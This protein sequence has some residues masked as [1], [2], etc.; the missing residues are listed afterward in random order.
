MAKPHRMFVVT[1]TGL[2]CAAVPMSLQ[3]AW[4][5]H[6]WGFPA[7]ALGMIIIGCIVT[8]IRR[9]MRAASILEARTP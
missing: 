8:A 4:L 1:V 7:I 2:A 3:K 9:L 6:A 5:D